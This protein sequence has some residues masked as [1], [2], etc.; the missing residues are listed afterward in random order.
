MVEGVLRLKNPFKIDSKLFDERDGSESTNQFI[1]KVFA[2]QLPKQMF[3]RSQYMGDAIANFGRIVRKNKNLRKLQRR[4]VEEGQGVDD[5]KRFDD[6]NYFKTGQENYSMRTENEMTDFFDTLLSQ[7]QQNKGFVGLT[8]R[9]LEINRAVTDAPS[10]QTADVDIFD[11]TQMA[12][13]V[14]I[15]KLNKFLKTWKTLMLFIKIV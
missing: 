2:L 1:K 8:N 3:Y 7:A 5:I 12:E 4:Q 14:P 15:N 11:Q 10:P 6:P 13:V 9:F